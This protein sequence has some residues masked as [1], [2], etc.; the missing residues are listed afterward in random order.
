MVLSGLDAD[1]VTDDESQQIRGHF[2]CGLKLGDL[3][4]DA[5][6]DSVSNICADRG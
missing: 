3:D 6:N 5:I 2:L 4:R 1:E